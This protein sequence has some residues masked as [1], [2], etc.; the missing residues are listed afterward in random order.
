M[1][2]TKS[3]SIVHLVLRMGL[4]GM[5]V[6]TAKLAADQK[7]R[8][9][10]VTVVC[11]FG[12]GCI[13]EKLQSEGIEVIDLNLQ[14][15]LG[16]MNL[17]LPLWRICTK[18]RADV[19]HVHTVGVEIPVAI[20]VFLCSV[21]KRILT[22]RAFVHYSGW[23][24]WWAKLG[25]KV[26]S[27]CFD[28]IVCISN[29]LKEHEIRYLGRKAN[30]IVVIWNG[31]DI[32]KFSP[33]PL[34]GLLR[35]RALGLDSVGPDTFVVG[36]GAQLKRFKDIPTLMRAAVHV[37]EQSGDKVLFIV[38]GTGRLEAELKALVKR[39]EIDDCFKFVGRIDNMPGFLNAI[40]VLALT[41]PFEGL[42]GIVLE[43]M[44][45]GKPVVTTDS[46]GIRDSVIDGQTGFIVPVGD[47]KS[48]AEAILKLADDRKLVERM[49]QAGLERVRRDFTL[50]EYTQS[51]WDL[52]TNADA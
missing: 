19:L 33:R 48:L 47:D 40:D 8:G 32:T 21:R 30:E 52:L 27:V 46:G 24:Y 10:D 20:A 15:G 28:K 34:E 16:M 45:T 11:L 14:R 23:R 13:G 50:E 25:A 6:S 31:V 43:A 5:E 18:R 51:Y 9:C 38:A 44:A 37:K 2:Q 7:Q 39:L 42:G 22:I 3:I 35:A 41:S 17:I 1:I 36:M 26:A 4:G 29:A 12:A 49:G